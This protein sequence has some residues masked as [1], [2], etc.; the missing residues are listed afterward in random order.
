MKKGILFF[1]LLLTATSGIA[2]SFT[3]SCPAPNSL[4][5]KFQHKTP[6]WNQYKAMGDITVVA[7]HTKVFQVSGDTDA[8]SASKFEWAT[9]SHNVPNDD[10]ICNYLGKTTSGE[11][12][13]PVLA[14]TYAQPQLKNCHFKTGDPYEC[15]ASL[16]SCELIC[17]E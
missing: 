2:G 8:Q 7:G 9:L 15:N 5:F 17:G 11:A 4:I 16:H 10:L 3:I 13:Y 12:A 6:T 14:E 1:A